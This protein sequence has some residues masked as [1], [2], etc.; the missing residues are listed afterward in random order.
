MAWPQD[1]T[2]NTVTA[3]KLSNAQN[4]QKRVKLDI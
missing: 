1:R 3:E 4:L 2:D